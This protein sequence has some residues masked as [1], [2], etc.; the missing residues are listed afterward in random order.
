MV[1]WLIDIIEKKVA[2]MASQTSRSVFFFF[3][4]LTIQCL[5]PQ[6]S[7]L[8]FG[9]LVQCNLRNRSTANPSY[10]LKASQ[11]KAYYTLLN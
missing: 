2:I 8:V 11:F 6:M 1:Y 7:H 5:T 4:F 3:V 10:K 9:K